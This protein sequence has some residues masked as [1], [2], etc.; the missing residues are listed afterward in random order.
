MTWPAVTIGIIAAAATIWLLRHMR[1]IEP[2]RVEITRR[3]LQYDNLPEELDGTMLCHV[4]DLHITADPRN[5]ATVAEAIRSVQADL[6]LITGDLIHGQRGVGA[7][8]EWLDQLGDALKPAVAILGNAEHKRRIPTGKL[9]DGL[10]QRGYTVLVNEATVLRVGRGTL[11]VVG[12]DD[13][14]SGH[15]RPARAYSDADP[16]LWT[17]TLVHSPEG[18]LSLEGRR[19]DL[20]LSGHTHGGQ[21]LLPGI[22]W[23]SDNTHHS[24]G[25]ISGWYDRS[26]IEIKAGI[27]HGPR[28]LYVSR[29]LGTS[30]WPLRL[31][32]R[33]ELALLKLRRS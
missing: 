32:C 1:K 30:G 16:T 9:I 21:I 24:V 18:I 17:L 13:P 28:G 27:R 22:G 5:S 14:H 19:A 31:R 3:E 33:P 20:V 10:R 25:L 29:G 8:M 26:D 11:Q 15:S 12:L 2:E 6:Y 23:L 7:L 4:S